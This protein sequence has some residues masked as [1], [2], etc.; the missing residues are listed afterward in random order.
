MPIRTR[1]RRVRDGLRWPAIVVSGLWLSAAL[2]AQAPSILTQP[3]DDLS[4]LFAPLNDEAVTPA[5]LQEPKTPPADYAPSGL[6][7]KDYQEAPGAGLYTIPG[8]GGLGK[9][10]EPPT[11][12]TEKYLQLG[13]GPRAYADYAPAGLYPRDYQ[14]APG[15]SLYRPIDPA[16][17][18]RADQREKLVERGLFPGSYLAP[19]TNTSFEFSGFVRLGATYDFQP[20]GTPDQFVTNSIPVPQTS[21]QNVNYSA[22]PTR[23]S[24]DT[25]T[26]TPYN[27][28]SVHTLLQFDFFSGSAP[29]VGSSSVPR[30]RFAYVDYGYF[31]VGQDTTVF[32]DPQSF[33][34]TVDFAGPRGLINSRQG[35]A[36]VT[37]PVCDNL[38]WAAAVEQPFSDITTNGLGN[39]VQDVPDFTSH[40]RYEADLFHVQA[41]TIVRT[42]GYQPLTGSTA[43]DVG[44]GMNLTGNVFPWA[45]LMGLD[46]VRELDPSPLERCRIL[47]QYSCG[48]GI[49]R[50]IQDTSGLGLDAAVNSAGSLETL[51]G[52]GWTLSYEHWYTDH[53]LTNVTYSADYV[54]HTDAQSGATYAGARYLAVS[55]WWVPIANMS[56]GVEY[57]WGLRKNVDGETANADRIQS[58]FQ[59]NF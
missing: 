41:S 21:G 52:V 27:D 14:E 34:R 31:R 40:L 33:P 2:W 49:S 5:A 8:P 42:I 26:P 18:I 4:A 50:Y 20:I 28:W 55:L 23:L 48:W 13:V 22:R 54:S 58:V 25:W 46:P 9:L 38:F 7:P 19:G 12:S 32:M 3:T 43:H 30:L 57:L 6:K 39:N 1:F 36:R 45:A 44:W 53:W 35:L 24:L 56:I 59:Y 47:A 11:L 29:G 17:P 10:F 16:S 37:L 51:Y 15:V